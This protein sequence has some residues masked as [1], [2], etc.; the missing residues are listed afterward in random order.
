MGRFRRGIDY[1]SGTAIK[2][3]IVSDPSGLLSRRGWGNFMWVKWPTSTRIENARA[4]D[5]A[6]LARPVLA[7]RFPIQFG[8][9]S[10]LRGYGQMHDLMVF[11]FVIASGLTVSGIVANAYRLAIKPT[12]ETN[13]MAAHWLIMMIAGPTVWIERATQSFRAKKFAGSAY[14][15]AV[16]GCLYWA[17]IIGLFMLS[18]VLAA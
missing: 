5:S 3:I 17:F 16:S 13:K 2:Q 9:E 12:P 4:G 1:V 10:Q 8:T 14:T 15:L 18:V 6:N 11:L 7:G